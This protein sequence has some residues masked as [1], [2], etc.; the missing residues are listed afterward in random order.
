MFFSENS[1]KL[2]AHQYMLFTIEFGCVIIMRSVFHIHLFFIIGPIVLILTI[3]QTLRGAFYAKVV[4]CALRFLRASWFY[5]HK[6]LFLFGLV[7][8]ISGL[9]VLQCRLWYFIQLLALGGNY[10]SLE[11]LQ[12]LL[13]RHDVWLQTLFKPVAQIGTSFILSFVF[14]PVA[15]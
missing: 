13:M 11:C 12:F 7:L 6:N 2:W 10:M 1:M 15:Q 8:P 3:L 5:H 4:F 9:L 14:K